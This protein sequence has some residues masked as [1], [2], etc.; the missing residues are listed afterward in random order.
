MKMGRTISVATA[1]AT[2]ALALLSGCAEG[3][4]ALVASAKD[5]L[6]KNDRAAAILQLKN[7]LQKN[8]DLAEARFLLGKAMLEGEESA[9]SQQAAGAQK[10]LR[11]ALELKYPADQVIPQL[12]GAMLRSGDSKK[13][14][15]EFGTTELTK[16]E[17]RAEL[18]TRLG[19]AHLVLRNLEASKAA[20]AAALA[21]IPD[22]PPALL[23]QAQLAAS[24]GDLP[25]ALAL[26]ES[27]LAKSPTLADGWQVKG[28]ILA[29]QGQIE[30]ALAAYR[31]AIEVKPD[32]LTAR[33]MIVNLLMRQGKTEE[34]GKEFAAMKKIAPTNPQTL[35]LQALLAY[36]DKDFV[37]ARDAIQLHLKAAPGNLTG[38]LLGA[39][40]DYQLQSYAM[41]E[42]ALDTVLQRAPKNVQA[43]Q[44]LVQTHLRNGRPGKALEV[45]QPLLQ[46]GKPDSNTF[47]LAGEVYAQNGDTAAAARYFEQAAA[48]DPANTRKRAAVGLLHVQKGD[49]EQGLAELESAAAGDTGVRADVAV[50]VVNLRQRKFDAALAA[51]DA[52]EKK[53]PDKPLSHNLRGAVLLA[54]GDAAGA[55]RSF[56][57]ALALDPAYFPAAASLARLDLADKKPEDAK[58]RF[59]DV[60]A[61]EPK[62]AQALLAIAALRA[63]SGGSTDEVAALIAKA[64][65]AAP[66]NPTPRLALIS[67]LLRSKE[68]KKAVAAA[69]E[70]LAALPDNPD[71]L[72]A[73]GQAHRAMGE[74]SQAIGIY[75][76][77]AKLRPESPVPLVRLAEVQ[78]ADKDLAA[79]RESAR[80]ALAMKPDSV[81][82]QRMLIALDLDSGKEPCGARH[83]ARHAETASERIHWLPARR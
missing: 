4:E 65:A 41:A 37:G 44:L 55:R 60:L 74:F 23:G 32:R 59:E 82:A 54:K 7:A 17:A 34:A 25:G 45:L 22:Y 48:L 81:E 80:K 40:I 42:T 61:K 66:A 5:F 27:A 13:M 24:Q 47:A 46:E 70:A 36:R 53:Q 31:K 33:Y 73:A 29:A 21:A 51:V 9:G 79:A 78:V 35:Y 12:A 11:K 83:G 16:P 26:A 2:I 50:V 18:Q 49:S 6:A 15:A 20:F 28:D 69:Q 64:V 3:P 8:P 71:I 72:D 19:K 10:E 77:L 57:R 1:V 67:H 30:T 56:E 75:S 43:R 58:K 38:V 52:I 14:V 76:R 63:Q 68:P 39:Q 62:N